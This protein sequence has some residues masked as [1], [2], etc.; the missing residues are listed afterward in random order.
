MK[1]ILIDP[2]SPLDTARKL[3]QQRPRP[4]VYYRGDFYEW[5]G[6]HY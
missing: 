4:L 5:R 2:K 6:T 3:N 1:K